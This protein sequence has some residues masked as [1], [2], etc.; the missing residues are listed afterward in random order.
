MMDR[1]SRRTKLKK[2]IERLE[3]EDRITETWQGQVRALDSFSDAQKIAVFDS[4]YE[5]A[6]EYV[7]EIVETGDNPKDWKQY[8]YESVLSQCL[9]ENVWEIINFMMR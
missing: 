1:N 3:K 7:K 2:Q 8:I 6:L 9:G 5:Q 4:M